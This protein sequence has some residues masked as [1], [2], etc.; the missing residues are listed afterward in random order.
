[1]NSYLVFLTR[2]RMMIGCDALRREDANLATN[3]ALTAQADTSSGHT[4][5]LGRPI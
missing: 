4:L 2:W 5:I 1:L 3:A